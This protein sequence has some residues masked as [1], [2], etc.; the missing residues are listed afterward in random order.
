MILPLAGLVAFLFAAPTPT[1]V[2]LDSSQVR[3]LLGSAIFPRTA[4][5]TLVGPVGDSA[6]LL[7]DGTEW[8]RVTWS[9][10]AALTRTKES[11]VSEPARFRKPDLAALLEWGRVPSGGSLAVG[12]ENARGRRS[13]SVLSWWTGV[14]YRH[15]IGRNLSLGGGLGW[16]G[17]LFGP[18]LE[19]LSGDSTL[20][21]GLAA[22]LGACVP[23]ACFDLVRHPHPFP[24]PVW[25]QTSLDSLVR[26]R[27]GGE[28][29]SYTDLGVYDPAWES[30]LTLH[31]G[32]LEYRA[33]W[34]PGLWNGAFQ[35]LGLW[36]LPAGVLR[37]GMGLEWIADRAA[38]RLQIGFAP[39]GRTVRTPASAPL[40]FEIEPPVLSFA[41][42]SASE[43]QLSLR[44][45]L[46]FADPF[47]P[48]RNHTP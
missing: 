2:L 40:R 36:D 37:F 16:D 6:V 4:D 3:A 28:F 20:P 47:S 35:S 43:F 45:G 27:S 38:S 9:Q 12:M 5:W 34:C 8:A 24:A 29:W 42:R 14:E 17:L 26:A 23:F 48:A 22:S 32:P 15:A 19:P 1:P 44:T 41:F 46:H 7:S 39:I 31:L 25:F 10:A 11:G 13:T 30:R 21:S 33:S 18:D